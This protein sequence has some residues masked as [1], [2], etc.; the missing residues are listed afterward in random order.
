M[1]TNVRKCPK[2]EAMVKLNG[3]GPSNSPKFSWALRNLLRFSCRLFR[4]AGNNHDFHYHIYNFGKS[5]AD[6][7]FLSDMYG[8]IRE[9]GS[10]YNR[11]YY[12]MM[13]RR[14]YD[15]VVIGGQSSY[16]EAQMECIKQ[17]N[18]NSRN[19]R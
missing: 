8:A 1:T 19:I 5:K 6:Q 9:K 10:W 16:E 2:C 7:Q 3:I 17:L 13:A 15:A 18:L 14:F 11:A 4:E 12:R